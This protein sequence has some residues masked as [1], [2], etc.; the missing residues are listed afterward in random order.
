MAKDKGFALVEL[1]VVISVIS[2]LMAIL[3]PALGRARA[4]AKRAT[5][6]SN[7]RQIGVAF[8]TYLDDNRDIMP[9]ACAYPWDITDAN[10]PHYT[11]PITKFLLPVLRGEKGV[12]VCKEDTVKKYYLRTGNTS[13]YYNGRQQTIFGW[14]NGLGG[15]SIT[16]SD[17]AKSGIKEKN[18]DVM[19][20]FD[21]IHPG[22]TGVYRKRV[23]QKNYLYADWHVSDY[24][25]Q[26]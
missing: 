21:P 17:L 8:K 22:F 6:W 10:D 20:D 1:L 23:G 9:L 25:N 16:A 13:Y 18:T 5:C 3:V 4:S 11:P 7:L 15:T 19:S 2:L 26:D 14:T 24:T 12:F